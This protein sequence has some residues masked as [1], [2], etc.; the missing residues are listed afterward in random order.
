MRKAAA[1]TVALI[2]TIMTVRDTRAL[3]STLP[4]YQPIETLAEHLKSVGS[5]TLRQETELWA[6]GFEGLY[7]DVRV[8]IE[9]AG[10]ATA[11]AAL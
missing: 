7:P 9:A 6:K 1:I 10:S 3:D 4:A 2:T 11:P 5:D 8:E